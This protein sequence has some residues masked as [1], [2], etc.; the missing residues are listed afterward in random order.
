MRCYTWGTNNLENR[1]QRG[2]G[3]LSFAV[4]DLGIQFRASHQG[5]ASE[6]E[7]LAIMALLNF[8]SNNP[9]IFTEQKLDIYTDAVLPVYQ[10]NKKAPVPPSVERYCRAIQRLR[11]T[12]QLALGWVPKEQNTAFTGVIDLPPPK[13]PAKI[14][15]NASDQP[16]GLSQNDQPNLK[17]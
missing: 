5:T 11:A 14:T 13:T 10:V 3:I 8:V 6:C 16:A 17:L 4:P 1:D 9:K 15:L 2:S 12:H 7:Y